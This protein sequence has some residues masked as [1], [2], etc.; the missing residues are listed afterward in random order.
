MARICIY[1][2]G[3]VG[4]YLGGRL[5]AASADIRFVGRP[6]AG[7][8]LREHGLTVTHYDGRRWTVPPG[9]IAF[10]TQPDGAAGA[11]LVLL[12]V[13][14][15]ATAGAAAELAPIL[16]ASATIVSFQNGI[17][18]GDILRAGLKQTV[19]DGMVPFNVVNPAPGQ[20]HQASQ[21]DLALQASLPGRP[22]L[23]AFAQAG[24]PLVR[25]A[26]MAPVQWAKLLLNLNNAVNA[27]AD[28]PLREELSQRDYRRCLALAQREALGLLRRAGI[29]PA[30]LMPLPASWIPML[31]ELPDAIFA[32][33][34]KRM[35]AID[36][37]ARSSMS[38]DLAAGRATEIDWINGEIV[39][40]AEKLG[41]AAPVNARL[42]ALI[43]AA[44]KAHPRPRWAA[45]D[46][47]AKLRAAA[48]I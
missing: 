37:Q 9:S 29:V 13:K 33:L 42:R 30:K 15:G 10:S 25:Y 23:S 1:G 45:D 47:L 21:G 16:D 39:R 3:S 17:G 20:F 11:D 28:R 22:D 7:A 4:C 6:A 44:E 24:L 31:L 2:A 19:L 41:G 35:L 14:S 34:A 12:T 40:L 46:L 26:E 43:R 36:P 18:N 48:G 27:L 5:L 38:D 8:V 32:R